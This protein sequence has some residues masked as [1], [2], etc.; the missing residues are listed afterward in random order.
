MPRMYTPHTNSAPSQLL[1]RRSFPSPLLLKHLLPP[2]N[3][4]LHGAPLR[5][6]HQ[7][8]PLPISSSLRPFQLRSRPFQ[9]QHDPPILTSHKQRSRTHRLLT[10]RN[11]SCTILPPFLRL[12]CRNTLNEL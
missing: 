10:P 5:K 2:S 12:R 9:P 6:P 11:L 4:H 8:N 1:R 7:Y 3:L